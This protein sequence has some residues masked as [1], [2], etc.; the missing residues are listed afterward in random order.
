VTDSSVKDDVR[1]RVER[2]IAELEPLVKEYEELRRIVAAI[3]GEA[4]AEER[5]SGQAPPRRR[6]TP[7][8]AGAGGHGARAEDALARIAAQPGV[9]VGELAA[10]MGI[11][12]TYLYR[13]LPR[14]EREGRLRK[15]GKGYYLA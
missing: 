8:G 6:L 4:A 9:P 2:R 12:T 7:S 13:L 14:L 10:Q 3:D 5:G 1:R 11:G 15:E